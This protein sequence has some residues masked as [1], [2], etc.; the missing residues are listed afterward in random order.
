MAASSECSSAR[1]WRRSPVVTA[2]YAQI[3]QLTA[4]RCVNM[5]TTGQMKPETTS[6]LQKLP[7]DPHYCFRAKLLHHYHICSIGPP[8]MLTFIQGLAQDFLKEGVDTIF[9]I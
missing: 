8:V 6:Q 5:D 4:G 2:D 1:L 7:D 3:S 9:R